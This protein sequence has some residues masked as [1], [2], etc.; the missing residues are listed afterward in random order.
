[1]DK[2]SFLERYKDSIIAEPSGRTYSEIE[3]DRIGKF[4]LV[5]SSSQ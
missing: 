1:M 5:G 2:K 4:M 3:Q